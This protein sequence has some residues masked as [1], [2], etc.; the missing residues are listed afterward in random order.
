MKGK[1]ETLNLISDLCFNSF[2]FIITLSTAPMPRHSN[3]DLLS[4]C[5]RIFSLVFSCP[6][7]PYFSIFKLRNKFGFYS[8][9]YLSQHPRKISPSL[10]PSLHLSFALSVYP[11]ISIHEQ[12]APRSL[13]PS[14]SSCFTCS[15]P[16][17]ALPS[18][19]APSSKKQGGKEGG[20]LLLLSPPVTAACPP[21]SH[22]PQVHDN[23]ADI[24]H[25]AIQ[26]GFAAE[27]FGG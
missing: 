4:C 16:S 26:R 1:K 11:H 5:L 7:F 9:I 6:L 10:P 25:G 27:T 15:F 13:P 22:L 20:D 8:L 19:P 3:G 12:A 17:P 23:S 18:F 2:F 21:S 14:P 24:V